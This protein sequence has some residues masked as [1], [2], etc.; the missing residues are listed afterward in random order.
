[1]MRRHTS[2]WRGRDV[3]GTFYENF[4]EI[5]NVKTTASYY[6]VLT[7]CTCG[8]LYMT[9][10][11]FDDASN[12]VVYHDFHGRDLATTEEAHELGKLIALDLACTEE[13]AKEVQVRNVA[14]DQLFCIHVSGLD[15]LAA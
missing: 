9:R 5:S 7:Q 8:D 1:M 2:L 3:D 15:L 10:F 6:H 11:F 13:G 14:G 4:I 12:G